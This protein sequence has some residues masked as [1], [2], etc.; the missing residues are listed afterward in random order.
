MRSPRLSR[1]PLVALSGVALLLAVGPVTPAGAAD[2]APLSVAVNND[3][4]GL[5]P[6]VGYD[7]YT[8]MAEHMIYDTLLAYDEDLRLQPSLAAAMPEV[9]ADGLTFTF[10]LRDSSFVDTGGEIV[11]PVTAQDVVFSLNRVLRPT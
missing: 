8:F 10:T 4:T 6:A 2:P 3:I 9:S 7:L 11:R 1:S 5:D